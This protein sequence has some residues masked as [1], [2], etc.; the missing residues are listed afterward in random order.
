MAT[1]KTVT[2]LVLNYLFPQ[3][4]YV[5]ENG[6]NG[7]RLKSVITI[8]ILLLLNIS[9]QNEQQVEKKGIVQKKELPTKKIK[10]PTKIQIL[11]GL[12]DK[13]PTYRSNG[14][15]FPVGKPHAKGYYNA[16]K[17]GKN[18]HLGDDW[19]S[20]K[21]G[22]S[23]LGDPI[24]ATSNGYVHFCEDLGGGWGKVIRMVHQLEDGRLIESVYAHCDKILVESNRFVNK[25]E[26]IGTIGNCNGMY[27]AHLHFEIR[28][29]IEMGIGG[30]Y[31]DNQTGYLDPTEFI[32]KN[33]K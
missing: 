27:L 22:N 11:S 12:F 32:N 19:N 4:Q 8:I 23:D 5:P 24:Y 17:F 18:N 2:D 26:K 21:G 13:N 15:D 30:G 1:D 10:A 9:C 33:R 7:L 31:S 3:P 28:S 14:F 16:Q 20:V 29:D 6:L 25:G